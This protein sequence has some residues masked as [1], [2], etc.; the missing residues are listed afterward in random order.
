MDADCTLIANGHQSETGLQMLEV[1]FLADVGS[2]DIELDY[3]QSG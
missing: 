2:L 3:H 1:P